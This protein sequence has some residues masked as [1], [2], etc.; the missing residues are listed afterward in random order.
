MRAAVVAS[1][2]TSVLA[3]RPFLNEPDTGIDEVL[4]NITAGTLAPLNAMVGLPDFEWAARKFLPAMNYTY[5]SNGAAG[6]WSSRNNVEAFHRYTWRPRQ[7]VDVTG[8]PET[9]P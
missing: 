2:A 5:Y 6:E 7:M 4:S 9:L 8:I 1:L 3:A